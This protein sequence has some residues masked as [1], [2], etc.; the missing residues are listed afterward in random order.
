MAEAPK[1]AHVGVDGTIN[2]RG[3]LMVTQNS[4]QRSQRSSLE[5]KRDVFVSMWGVLACLAFSGGLDGSYVVEYQLGDEKIRRGVGDSFV[6][7]GLNGRVSAQTHGG[8]Q[9]EREGARKRAS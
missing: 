2:A 1:L 5:V 4:D 3:E 9:G 7:V 6:K 8:G